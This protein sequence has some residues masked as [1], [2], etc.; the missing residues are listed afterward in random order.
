MRSGHLPIWILFL[1]SLFGIPGICG[2]APDNGAPVLFISSH[3]PSR[4]GTM[5]TVLYFI[6]DLGP[7]INNK[8]TVEYMDTDSY[9]GLIHGKD[10]MA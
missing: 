4:D 5:N 9:E 8:I 7:R 3:S 2:A 10:W 1:F 6:E